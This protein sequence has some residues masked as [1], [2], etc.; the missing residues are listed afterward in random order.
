ME[1]KKRLRRY[2]REKG[3]FP[4][5]VL[6]PRDIDILKSLTDYRFLTTPQILALHPG[7]ERNLQRR[8]Q[9]L[10][11]NGFVH[12]PPQQLSYVRPQGHMIYALGDR[13]ADLLAEQVGFE[14]GKI[15][16]GTKNREVKE[17]YILHTLMISQ[18]RAVL[19]LALNNHSQAILSKWLQGAELKDYVEV[20]GKNIPLVPDAFFTI[21][22]AQSMMHFFL[23]ADRSTMTTQRFLRK[24]KSYWEW[25]KEG[26]H[27]EK[28]GIKAF[29]VLTIVKTQKRKESLREIA[30]K[31]DD[32]EK[33]SMMFWFASEEDYTL[34]KPET[35]LS[36]IWQTPKDDAWHSILE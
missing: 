34:E 1:E 15:D 5:F 14:R 30:K 3:A 25:W 2:R 13:G 35:L 29:R 16:W 10:F 8:L 22:D 21:E 18:V 20:D 17:R 12:R 19:T 26:G 4:N 27:S 36:F 7:G 28:Y 6:Q 24:M 9:K 31:A 33:G 23:E 11:H 32:S